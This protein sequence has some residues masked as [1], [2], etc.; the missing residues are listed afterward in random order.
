MV[1]GIAEG[2]Q[3]FEEVMASYGEAAPT[4]SA[5][6]QALCVLKDPE[7][8]VEKMDVSLDRRGLCARDLVDGLRDVRDCD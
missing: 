8:N 5:E 7:W 2:G 3:S 1:K 4:L 6:N